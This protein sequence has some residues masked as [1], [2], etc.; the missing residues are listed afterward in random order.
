MDVEVWPTNTLLEPDE[1]LVLEVSG[2]DTRGVGNFSHDH[3]PGRDP[4]VS[5][6]LDNIDV[7]NETS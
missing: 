4:K 6:G 5:D 3:P 7:G 1:T 2:H